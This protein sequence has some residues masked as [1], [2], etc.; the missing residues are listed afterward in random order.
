MPGKL[1]LAFWKYYANTS[2]FLVLWVVDSCFLTNCQRGHIKVYL[3]SQVEKE[4]SSKHSSI[5]SRE[6][7]LIR[8]IRIMPSRDLFGGACQ[9]VM[10]TSLFT[11]K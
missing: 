6:S 5:P 3:F 4:L 9:E 1:F 11:L 7:R 10:I 8:H 2:M